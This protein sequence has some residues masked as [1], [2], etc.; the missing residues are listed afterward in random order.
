MNKT[1][2]FQCIL[3]FALAVTLSLS[4]SLKDAKA[5]SC[6]DGSDA[7]TI[8]LDPVP[9]CDSDADGYLDTEECGGILLP[10]ADEGDDP[11][12]MVTYSWAEC[13]AGNAE[14]CL[15]PTQRDLYLI[16]IPVTALP[17]CAGK[18]SLLPDNFLYPTTSGLGVTIHTVQYSQ[19]SQTEYLGIGGS[20]KAVAMIEDC[21]IDNLGVAGDTQRGVPPDGIV[22]SVY[23][24][25]IRETLCAACEGCTQDADGDDVC[26][27]ELTDGI[28]GAPI[29]LK[30]LIGKGVVSVLNHEVGHTGGLSVNYDRKAGFHWPAGTGAV[31]DQF[32]SCTS[33]KGKTK[34]YVPVVQA[35]PDVAGYH[36][37]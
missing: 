29:L 17:E 9:G 13:G 34:C 11:A 31:L 23:S 16:I 24:Y 20:Q 8:C 19:T 3:T 1:K 2:S 12:N 4:F 33:R 21:S 14:Y 30:D 28:T 10:T 7:A 25:V 36:L 5:Y 26:N 18:K 32:L 22:G 35:E 27:N 15:D 6:G 37:K